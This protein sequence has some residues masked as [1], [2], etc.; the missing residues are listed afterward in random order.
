MEIDDAFTIM[1]GLGANGRDWLVDISGMAENSHV[2][3]TNYPHSTIENIART[4]TTDS[5]L[6]F[7]TPVFHS[8]TR[9][10]FMEIDYTVPG[11][12]VMTVREDGS[13]VFHGSVDLNF[14]G[15]FD[16]TANTTANRAD[17]ELD[18]S[19][20]PEAT[21][22][23]IADH[24]RLIIEDV[25]DSNLLEHLTV[26]SFVDSIADDQ[27]IVAGGGKLSV[28]MTGLPM[29][30]LTAM[31]AADIH[32]ADTLLIG[33]MSASDTVSISMGTLEERLR[34]E[35]VS[36]VNLGIVS[37]ESTTVAPSR[38]AVA[39]AVAAGGGGGGTADGV[40]QSAALAVVGLDLSLT[41][42]RSIGA[43]V[44]ASVTLPAAA[45][46]GV[47]DGARMAFSRA[48]PATDAGAFARQRRLYLD[49]AA[50]R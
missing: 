24:D 13:E 6:L 26:G 4:R 8:T 50:G 15:A 34:G 16:V 23:T 48:I 33:D 39:F 45:A 42:G 5:H 3:V 43:E 14:I 21:S 40:V 2:G 25:S 1:V 38:R 20:L 27:G 30:E 29:E 19:N 37:A 11:S 17:V 22:N 9:A 41:L 35:Y 36:D 12:G 49:S 10:A 44:T 7:G 32:D 47:L 31:T 28:S 46:D 18:F